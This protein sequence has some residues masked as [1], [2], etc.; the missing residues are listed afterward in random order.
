M[1]QP[2]KGKQHRIQVGFHSRFPGFGGSRWRI[3]TRALI[4]GD[5]E[6]EEQDEVE[7]D[8]DHDHEDEHVHGGRFRLRSCIIILLRFA[9]EAHRDSQNARPQPSLADDLHQHSFSSAAIKL[10]IEDLLPGSK[11][12]FAFGNGNDHFTPHNLSLH[13]GIGIILTRAVVLVL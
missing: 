8:Q 12:Q 1:S 9:F 13:V 3:R 7:N 11:V 2:G 4:W 5:D 6:L 10:A